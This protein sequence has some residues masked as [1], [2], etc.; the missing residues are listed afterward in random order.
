MPFNE[1]ISGIRHYGIPQV[2]RND[3]P[4][5]AVASPDATLFPMGYAGEWTLSVA[6]VVDHCNPG[7]CVRWNGDFPLLYRR[8][9]PA[10]RGGRPDR[11]NT[12]RYDLDDYTFWQMSVGGL[13]QPGSTGTAG[14]DLSGCAAG[15]TFAYERE[16]GA[17][18][19]W[20]VNRA[21]RAFPTV[22]Y[23][24]AV[25]LS[26]FGGGLLLAWYAKPFDQFDPTV[27][28]EFTLGSRDDGLACKWPET[29]TVAP[30]RLHRERHQGRLV[31]V[32]NGL[33]VY[34]IAVNTR[35]F[36]PATDVA[37]TLP[38]KVATRN[39]RPVNAAFNT[40]HSWEWNKRACNWFCHGA[41][42]DPPC[43]WQVDA[44]PIYS[45]VAATG[46]ANARQQQVCVWPKHADF[47][48]QT[49]NF[50]GGVALVQFV[51]STNP[52]P[53][54]L[55]GQL[56]KE[57]SDNPAHFRFTVVL[58]MID[59][60]GF[61]HTMTYTSGPVTRCDA[62]YTLNQD[63]VFPDDQPPPDHPQ[64]PP[65]VT[66]TPLF[67]GS[68]TPSGGEATPPPLPPGGGDGSALLVYCGGDPQ[69]LESYMTI[70]E[71]S[72]AGGCPG[73]IPAEALLYCGFLAGIGHIYVPVTLAGGQITPVPPCPF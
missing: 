51:P 11:Q 13:W 4:V 12:W 9:L 15:K 29:V 28:N 45:F 47:P 42:G 37:R 18:G 50:D 10:V 41:R 46:L 2:P 6:G 56:P 64:F 25:Q 72:A 26:V 43:C 22:V 23:I 33:P 14:V 30:V 69:D 63:P 49:F 34:A 16:F 38:N 58:S 20:A 40:A 70:P 3:T 68:C 32:R 36:N 66:I 57:P 65:S 8:P 39:D 62:I 55:G 71:W 24:A 27:V 31:S 35:Y 19:Q 54:E 73:G 21:G 59:A 17:T 53:L 5:F 1:P 61:R 44:G 48:E 67:G 7:L 52:C 60:N